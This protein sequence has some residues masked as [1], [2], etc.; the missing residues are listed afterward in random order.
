[1]PRIAGALILIVLLVATT[2]VMPAQAQQELASW[3]PGPDASGT[4]TYLAFIEQPPSGGVASGAPFVIS[5]WL[6][7]KTAQGWAGFDQVQVFSG[8]MGSGGTMLATALVGLD[9]PDVAAATGNPDWSE[10]GFSAEISASALQPGVDPLLIYGHT[11]AKG[12]WYTTFDAFVSAAS[13]ASLAPPSVSIAVPGPEA[14]IPVT[15]RSYTIKGSAA[16]PGVT[17]PSLGSGIDQVLVYLGGRREDP[18]SILLGNASI[19]GDQWSL[20][21]S[22]DLYPWGSTTLYVYAHARFSGEEAEAVQF[23]TIS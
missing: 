14:S 6:I 23:I 13:N 15:S 12:W 2:G 1:V 18:R 4:N 19:S 3:Q 8:P 21:F 5:G 17:S 16:D 7:D 11:P 9:R 10:S 20:T 22:P